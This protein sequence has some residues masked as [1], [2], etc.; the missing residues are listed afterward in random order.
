MII[1]G[2]DALHI[3][4][5]ELRSKISIIPQEPVL[6]SGSLRLNLD[7]FG[8]SDDKQL[9]NVLEDVQLKN[10]VKHVPAG[11]DMEVSEDG[12]NFSVGQR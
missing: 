8:K 6:F 10:D 12:A 5:H 7:P 4:L 9:W 2:I 1:D 11:L 3:G